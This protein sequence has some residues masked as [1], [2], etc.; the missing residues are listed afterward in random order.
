MEINRNMTSVR[1]EKLWIKTQYDLRIKTPAV[2][3]VVLWVSGQ[4]RLHFLNIT[5]QLPAAAVPAV[6]DPPQ[7]DHSWWICGSR[8]FRLVSQPES[9]D[10]D[11]ILSAHK[12]FVWIQSAKQQQQ[13]YLML[14]TVRK[15]LVLILIERTAHMC[16]ASSKH[17]PLTSNCSNSCFNKISEQMSAWINS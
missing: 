2:I 5:C 16:T 15:L 17:S 4:T 14:F 1:S 9:G 3:A 10:R 12:V 7:S 6:S 8:C 11:E 13:F